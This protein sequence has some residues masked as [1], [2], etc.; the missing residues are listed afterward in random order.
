[1]SGHRATEACAGSLRLC[2]TDA[3]LSRI[4]KAELTTC[5][6]S[7]V[8]T[9][10]YSREPPAAQPTPGTEDASAPALIVVTWI[11][12]LERTIADV[13]RTI[14]ECIARARGTI[15]HAARVT[16][17][18]VPYASLTDGSRCL[19]EYRSADAVESGRAAL[20]DLLVGRARQRHVRHDIVMC[21]ML[22][23]SGRGRRRE[24]PSA[25]QA[26]IRIARGLA[27]ETRTKA[28]TYFSRYELRLCADTATDANVSSPSS[29][30]R[31][32]V[33]YSFGALDSTR[34]RSGRV[35]YLQSRV[36]WSTVCA[37]A[38]AVGV[39]LAVDSDDREHNALDALFNE[40]VYDARR[41]A[42]PPV[43]VAH[44]A[45][46]EVR[47]LDSASVPAIVHAIALEP[48]ATWES[49]YEDVGAITGLDFASLASL[50]PRE[51]ECQDG[52]A[53][54]P[55]GI[56]PPVRYHVGGAGDVVIF[57]P[58]VG[59]GVEYYRPAV[60]LLVKS[61]KVIVWRP[62]GKSIADTRSWLREDLSRYV[63]DIRQVLEHEGVTRCHVVTWCSGGRLVAR[64][65]ES[66]GLEIRSI[67]LMAPLS[68][69]RDVLTRSASGVEALCRKLADDSID[70]A[71]FLQHS[72]VRVREAPLALDQFVATDE[73][74]KSPLEY[75]P[76]AFI[77]EDM[78]DDAETMKDWAG[79]TLESLSEVAIV[80]ERLRT[81]DGPMLVVLGTHDSLISYHAARRVA[82]T[83]PRATV[84]TVLGGNHYF[85]LEHGQAISRL[86]RTFLR[87]RLSRDVSATRRHGTR[88]L[89]ESSGELA[90]APEGVRRLPPR[91]SRRAV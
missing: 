90:A 48:C 59:I 76:T 66:S 53:S 26:A 32:L 82:A 61:F 72:K 9:P 49:S 10:L 1:M 52:Q 8:W 80:Y 7:V 35:V 54:R 14:D 30:A 33:D 86:L 46:A 50:H 18:V 60:E 63:A 57:L 39:P 47:L 42:E 89:V 87:R 5:C 19:Q 43:D 28:P 65:I 3:W 17:A 81:F 55:D 67:A 23:V 29:V 38:R 40:L 75:H 24:H 77:T 68:G 84:A 12:L 58:P 2:T 4:L 22:L 44:C 27:D 62:R 79:A 78:F 6:P 31:W 21:P 37:T 74:K 56:A 15:G 11:D 69:E 71:R 85:L 41:H 34:A 64:L 36:T 16:V 51:L 88:I 20:G 83:M 13:A 45:D 70:I 25:L 73:S 91:S